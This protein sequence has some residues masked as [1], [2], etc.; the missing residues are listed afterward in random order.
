M[1]HVAT[2]KL[3]VDIPS[4]HRLRDER[5][6]AF[7]TWEAQWLDSSRRKLRIPNRYDFDTDI[8]CFSITASSSFINSCQILRLLHA[9]F[10]Q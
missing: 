7:M 5:H 3:P 1:I 10:I 2:L 4:R 8:S 6:H 9:L